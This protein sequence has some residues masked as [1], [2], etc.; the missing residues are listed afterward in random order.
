MGSYRRTAA[1]AIATILS[2]V[3]LYPIFTGSVWFW[4]GVGSTVIVAVAG[5]LTRLR[6]LPLAICLAG[7]V[8]A[9]LLYLNV[10]FEASSSL[11]WLIPTSSSL[12]HL[13]DLA[14]TGFSE[15]ARY[16][17]PVP[18]LSGMVLLGAAGIG[19][20]A[21]LTDLIAVRLGSAAFAGL[22]LLLLFTEPFTLS[23]S[24]GWVGTTAVFI[25][26]ATG[27]LAMLST[28]GRERIREW[29]QRS[30][31]PA[32]VPDTRALA[33]A[34][35]RVG[36]TSVLV[37]LCIP[38]FL[39]GLHVTRLFGSGSP[40]IGGNTPGVGGVGFPSLQ[41]ELSKELHESSAVPVLQYTSTDATPGYLQVY[42][43]D[44]LTTSGWQPSGPETLV[45]GNR[46]LPTAPGL[47]ASAPKQSVTTNV[48]VAKGV[49]QDE[50]LA[51]PAPYPAVRV[52]SPEGTLAA[53]P[54]TLMVL[55]P[56]A[57]LA[58]LRYSVTSWDVDPGASALAA[59]PA[60]PADIKDHD[61]E[62][63]SSYN[64]LLSL[65]QSITAGATTPYAKAVALQ[66]W[67]ANGGY[68]YTLNA[69][70]IT[71]ASQLANFLD[72]THS[73]YCQQFSFAMAVLARLVGI[74]SQ[75]AYGF[76]QGTAEKNST[77]LVTTHD[78][79]AWPELY[80]QGFGWL[81][82]EPT[83]AGAGGQ[84]T[85]TSP[86]YAQQH[87][88]VTGP[89]S[90]VPSSSAPT[91]AAG[92]SIKSNLSAAG[93]ERQFLAE[94][95]FGTTS[96]SL[97]R[98]NGLNP[99]ELAGLSL[100][101][102]LAVLAVVPGLVRAVIRRRRWRAGARAGDAGL[103][104]AAWLEL[105]DDL[106]DYGTGYFPSESP[107]A[108]ADRVTK[109]LKLA[110]ADDAT[111]GL[112]RVT[113][114]AERARYSAQPASGVTLREDSATIR[115]AVVAAAPRRA[116]WRARLFPSSVVSPA[117]LTVSQVTDVFGR[118]NRDRLP[119]KRHEQPSSV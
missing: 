40:G 14:G 57:Q 2:S 65:A 78:A 99:W 56:G 5:T 70:T 98:G 34:G 6:R 86:G 83:P 26:A 36:V 63:P 92:R 43:L 8:L 85:A 47:S 76:T 82:F 13:W 31:S 116:R 104:Q 21:V 117:A 50:L 49:A 102:L 20:A 48:T 108:L 15:S 75:V 54:S 95:G 25:L 51:L 1:A 60:P 107:R 84:G 52:I 77:W 64:S 42:V 100:L 113:M 41:T 11:V 112:R 101:A 97:S 111:A 18:E 67:L 103:A 110:A 53:D 3:A 33:A 35:R 38:M 74:P 17:P 79:H 119:G 71:N 87:T 7:S 93:R 114:A 69:P 23:V 89:I 19:L 39:P 9:L 81:R 105:R 4:A 27:Y 10:A 46:R 59:A 58:G 22:P 80:F 44:D 68:S 12:R 73:G 118:L 90:P 88:S 61:L 62:V 30:P 66:N 24:R 45:F 32:V 96:Q 91:Q 16:A 29:E 72:N 106:M 55:D 94:G 109:E 37:A 115:R 28:E